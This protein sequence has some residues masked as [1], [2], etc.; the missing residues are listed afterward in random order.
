MRWLGGLCAPDVDDE[1]D[2]TGLPR[3]F[4]EGQ[5]V[6]LSGVESSKGRRFATS[7]GFDKSVFVSAM[8]TSSIDFDYGWQVL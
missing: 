2:R 6:E 4:P 7:T 1:T 5:Q 8:N 3:I